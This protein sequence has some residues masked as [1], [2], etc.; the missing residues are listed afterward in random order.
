MQP[1]KHYVNDFNISKTLKDVSD[2]LQNFKFIG[3]MVFEIAG[4]LA[5]PP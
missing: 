2:T 4:G 3:A 1:S 5:D